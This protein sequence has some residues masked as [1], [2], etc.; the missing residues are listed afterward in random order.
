[1]VRGFQLTGR[2]VTGNRPMVESTVGKRP[3]EPFMEEEEEQR[4]LHAL[5]R[6]NGRIAIR[7]AAAVHGL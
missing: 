5:R 4:N 3:A 1:V 7:H 2:L 6:E